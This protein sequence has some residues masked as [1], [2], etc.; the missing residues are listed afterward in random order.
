MGYAPANG[1]FR[2]RTLSFSDI[3]PRT[4]RIATRKFVKPPRTAA[5]KAFE[6]TDLSAKIFPLLKAEPRSTQDLLRLLPDKYETDIK[7]ALHLLGAKCHRG[8]R[9]LPKWRLP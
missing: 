2:P 6:W 3:C 9:G 5:Q 8:K 7:G 4:S 1:S